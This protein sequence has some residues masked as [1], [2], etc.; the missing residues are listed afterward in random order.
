LLLLENHLYLLLLVQH[1]L[2]LHLL[3]QHRWVHC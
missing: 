1:L 2:Q 3:R